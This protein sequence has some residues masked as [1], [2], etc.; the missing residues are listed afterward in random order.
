MPKI[1]DHDARRQDIVDA[2]CD[3]IADV[4]IDATT[5]RNIADRAG[6]TTG[7]VTHYFSGK[8]AILLAALRSANG[9]A[10]HRMLDSIGES[11]GSTAL[12]KL[13]A[14][15]LPLDDLRRR[16][17]LVW[18]AFWGRATADEALRLEQQLRYGEWE[19]LVQQVCT[20]NSYTHEPSAF[21]AV[22]DGIGIRATLDPEHF[23]PGR[24]MEMIRNHLES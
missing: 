15:A 14:E 19:L 13:A 5:M 18:L 6:C 7:L 17:W 10:G 1:V 24:Q 16:E 12:L 22:I 4:G 2:T 3:V 9:A 11:V 21:V 20:D 8:S 23:P